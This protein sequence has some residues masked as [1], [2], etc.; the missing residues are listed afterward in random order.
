[1]LSG[2]ILQVLIPDSKI[3]IVRTHFG[4]TPRQ[5]AHCKAHFFLERVAITF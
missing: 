4:Y 5:N 2:M 3:K 1:M